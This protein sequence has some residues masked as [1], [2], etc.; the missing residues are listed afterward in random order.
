MKNR[1]I[2]HK[3][4]HYILLTQHLFLVKCSSETNLQLV[5]KLLRIRNKATIRIPFVEPRAAPDLCR[6]LIPVHCS[7]YAVIELHV[8]TPSVCTYDH[9]FRVWLNWKNEKP[10]ETLELTTV[11]LRCQG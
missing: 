7:P 8:V 2:P 4:I 1:C 9:I 11:S 3:K 5:T 6:L 10:T